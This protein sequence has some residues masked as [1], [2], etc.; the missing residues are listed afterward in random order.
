MP[1]TPRL[2]FPGARHHVMNHVGGGRSPF[3]DP[4]DLAIFTGVLSE[5]PGRFA[6]RVHGYALMSNHYHVMVEVPHGNLPAFMR[7]L[8]GELSRLVNRR[9]G[10]D[11]PLFRARYHNRLVTDDPYWR[12]LLAYVHLNPVAGGLVRHP[13]DSAW[14]S[15]RAYAGLATSPPWLY[16]GE[17]LELYGSEAIYREEIT[18]I[19]AGRAHLPPEFDEALIWRNPRTDGSGLVRP[20]S[21]VRTLTREA[22]LAEVARVTGVDAKQL[23]VDVRGRSGNAPRQL[24]AWWLLRCTALPRAEVAALL[25][26]SD[27]AVGTAASRVRHATDEELVRWRQ[28]LMDAWWGPMEDPL[29]DDDAPAQKL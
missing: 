8:G 10:L 20:P 3:R 7:H 15:H 5:L 6:A 14:T 22:A 28:E 2:D 18:A 4:E 12:H 24:A 29:P 9:H 19:V 26:M 23:M 27:G 25:G 11:G 13:D 1:R 17:L 21:T 16:R